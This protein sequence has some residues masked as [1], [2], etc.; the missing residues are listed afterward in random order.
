MSMTQR[1]AGMLLR[2]A[3]R[4]EKLGMSTQAECVR[5]AARHMEELQASNDTITR[6][7]KSMKTVPKDGTTVLVLLEG[8]DIP[9]AVKWCESN[10]F[11][12]TDGADWYMPWDGT[13][14]QPHDLRYWMHCPPDP[15]EL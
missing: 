10:H 5:Q 12:A 14:V 15:D 13:K 3:G 7:W 2:H 6:P 1:Y 9:K 8:S 4:L 11:L